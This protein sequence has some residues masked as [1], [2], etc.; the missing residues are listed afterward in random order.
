M[1]QPLMPRA[2]AVWL[3]ENTGLTFDQ[4]AD[5]CG[6][7]PLEVQ[8]IADGEVA[9][10]IRGRD[11]IV[12]GEIT[13]EQIAAAETDS[14]K[15]LEVTEPEIADQHRPPGP[16]YTPVSKRQNRP[17]AIAWLIKHHPE[18]TDSQICHL[19][20]T[21]KPTIVSVRERN[22]WNSPNIKAQDPVS[23]GICSQVDL[24]EAITQA[25]R[26]IQRKEDR[27]ARALRK[28]E[29]EKTAALDAANAP[30]TDSTPAAA[31]NDPA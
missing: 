11:P 9:A 28:A 29:R 5:F 3:V 17:D 30:Q 24:D 2:T 22:H 10:G 20:G 26:R 4:I 21:T 25:V 27:E 6:L 7:H 13:R 12:A 19:V 23:L 16:R 31:E 14:T 18:L 15:R 8:G 1:S